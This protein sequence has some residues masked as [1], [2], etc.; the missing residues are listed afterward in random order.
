MHL[1]SGNQDSTVGFSIPTW[2]GLLPKLMPVMFP[3]FALL[4]YLGEGE[5]LLLLTAVATPTV[6][7]LMNRSMTAT[8]PARKSLDSVTGLINRA[9]FEVEMTRI[10]DG[11]KA[12]GTNTACLMIQLD[13]FHEVIE[14]FGETAGEKTLHGVAQRLELALRDCDTVSRLGASRFAVILGD[15]RRLDLEVCIQLSRRLQAAV[16][17]PVPLD[18]MNIYVSCCVGFCLAT[19]LGEKKAESLLAATTIA[20]DE[21]HRHTAENLRAYSSDMQQKASTRQKLMDEA[22]SALSTGQLR[23]WFQPQVS[24]D[25]GRITGFEALVRWEHPTRG[26]IPPNDFLDAL[27]M[28]GSWKGLAMSCW[29]RPWPRKKPGTT[30][31]SL[32]HK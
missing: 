4:A 27:E 29:T 28:A 24:T 11:V 6:F 26:V 5:W 22:K 10:M 32:C 18:G 21:A 23:A 19:R 9:G 12:N 2:K 13:D 17:E 25:T 31:A 3:V 20:L 16:E 30:R 1:R 7:M 14:K 15:V 8:D